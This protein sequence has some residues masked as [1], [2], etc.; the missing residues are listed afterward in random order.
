MKLAQ[1][2]K[3][4]LCFCNFQLL[5]SSKHVIVAARR[6]LLNVIQDKRLCG[7]VYRKLGD[8]TVLFNILY[9]VKVKVS[10]VQVTEVQRGSRGIA[11]SLTSTLDGGG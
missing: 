7:E 5:L 9:Y 3:K 10:L 11:P 4:C 8:I 1:E 6:T 2:I